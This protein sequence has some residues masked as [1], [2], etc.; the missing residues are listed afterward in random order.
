MSYAFILHWEKQVAQY[1]K[2]ELE[3]FPP[4]QKLQMIQNA[5]GDV[6]ELACIKQI[7]DENISRGNSPCDVESYLELLLLT[8]SI[9]YEKNHA[10]SMKHKRNVYTMIVGEVIDI[11]SDDADSNEQYYEAFTVETIS[12]S[13]CIC[14]QSAPTER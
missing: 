3:S 9:Y 4:K 8:C 1:E 10:S 11:Q 7:D 14:I 5:V 12:Q 13:L 6:N 2:L